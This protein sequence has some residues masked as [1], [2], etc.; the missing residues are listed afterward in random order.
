MRRLTLSILSLVF[1]AACQPTTTELTEE[2]KG[3]IAADIRQVVAEFWNSVEVMD[4]DRWL[5]HWS[6]ELEPF[7]QTQPAIAVNLLTIVQ[8]VDDW[9][10]GWEPTF[11]QRSGHDIA[12]ENEHVAVLAEDIVLHVSR[13]TFTVSD[14][15][16]NTTEP[17]PW[18]V[19]TVWVH[20]DAEWK[21]LHFHQ[22]WIP[23][24]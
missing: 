21:I 20:R 11:A 17:A 10:A 23:T 16:G 15:L 19:S 13:G 18:T 6:P 14:T 22:S 7:F 12:L 3:E 2:Q 5:D 24:S 1:L 4:T 8:T 9:R